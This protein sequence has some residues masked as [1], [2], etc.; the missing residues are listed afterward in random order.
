M[1][2][3][4]YTVP[5]LVVLF[6]LLVVC[7]AGLHQYTM[8]LVPVRR[9]V[10]LEYLHGLVWVRCLG[11][12]RTIPLSIASSFILY[13]NIDSQR[14]WWLVAART[15]IWERAH[16]TSSFTILRQLSVDAYQMTAVRFFITSS[17][18]FHLS[19]SRP[20]SAARW[21]GVASVSS[22]AAAAC[23]CNLASAFKPPELS[24][25]PGGSDA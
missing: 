6:D 12:S 17:A 2:V 9:F 16:T 15:A 11:V 14:A 8:Q 22:A 13:D 20:S 7:L 19:A 18:Y 21:L 5:F 23:V 3:C 1:S 10:G 4:P 24:T 25:P